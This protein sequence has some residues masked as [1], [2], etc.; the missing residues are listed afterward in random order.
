MAIVSGECNDLAVR[1]DISRSLSKVLRHKLI[2]YGI[3]MSVDGF[4]SVDQLLQVRCLS[5][6]SVQ[7]VLEAVATSF[8]R[9]EARFETQG[10]GESLRIRAT[11]KHS[12]PEVDYRMLASHRSSRT[13]PPPPPGSPPHSPRA[14]GNGNVQPTLTAPLLCQPPANLDASRAVQMQPQPPPSSPPRNSDVQLTLTAPLLHQPPP[15]PDATRAAQMQP[16]P[17]PSSPPPDDSHAVQQPIASLLYQPPPHTGAT[18]PLNPADA[19]VIGQTAWSRLPPPA[20]GAALPSKATPAV[21][22]GLT[23]TRSL[24]PCVPKPAKRWQRYHSVA[25]DQSLLWWW[26]EVDGI[27]C[28]LEAHPGKWC[29][30][31]DPTSMDCYWWLSDDIWF[32]VESGSTSN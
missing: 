7:D 31:A 17:P 8:K 12:L 23:K 13:Q 32:W 28:F 6:V 14:G 16:P 21:I 1:N 19:Q 10:I 26:C 11:R 24:V 29:K 20:W 30:Y 15:N 27:D 22:D 9:N 3:P 4:A 25:E 5:G 2:K 18:S